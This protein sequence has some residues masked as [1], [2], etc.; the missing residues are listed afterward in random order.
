[1]RKSWSR[2]REDERTNALCRKWATDPETKDGR[3]AANWLERGH[4]FLLRITKSEMMESFSAKT[5]KHFKDKHEFEQRFIFGELDTMWDF[6][7]T[8][9]E[10]MK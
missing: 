6:Y 4:Q 5:K 1:M 10:I 7:K 9:N 2:T 3:E 8:K